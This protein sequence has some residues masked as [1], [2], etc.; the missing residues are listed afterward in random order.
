MK[1][2]RLALNRAAASAACAGLALVAA[3]AWGTEGG[4][5]TYAN[6]AESFMAGALPPPGLYYL[7][8][9]THYSADRLNDRHGDKVPVDFKVN[10]TANVSRLVYMT[11][12]QILGGTYGVYGLIP[13][14]HVSASLTTPAGHASSSEWG[15]GD[16]S[17]S[18]FLVAWHSKNWH[19]AAAIEF[20]APTGRYD[21]H[22]L[23]NI[24]RNYWSVQPVY[25]ATW[26]GDSGIEVSGKF[27]YD[28]NAENN[29]TDYRSGQ[30]FHFDYGVGYH[31][32]PW[33]LGVGG[34]YYKQTTDDKQH[35]SKVGPDGNRGQVFAIGPALKYDFSKLSLEARY[36]KEMDVENRPEGYKL[37]L[38]LVLPL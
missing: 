24:G 14:A 25:A 31:A 3:N 8:Y 23:G 38:K 27:M 32:G 7:N 36:Q 4:G 11:N 30:E 5:G 1:K 28:F 9:L 20:T 19:S 17:F 37:W 15:V 12:Q 34:Y 22:E 26:L 18:P 13:L 16:L 10:A 2:H 33:T 21:R 6:G 29:D 35:G